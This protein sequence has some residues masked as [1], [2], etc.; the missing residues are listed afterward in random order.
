VSD[1]APETLLWDML[2]GAM[3]TKALGVAA[4]LGVADALAAGPRP[5]EELARV[6]RAEPDVLNR[7]L[8]ALASDGV[9]AEDEPGVFRNNEASELLL[10]ERANGWPQFAHLFAGVFYDAANSLP[11]RA[12]I[13]F[14]PWLAEHPSERAAFD[15]AMAGEKQ[16]AADRLATL[17]WRGDETVVDVGGGNGALLL[18]LLDRRPTLRG[19]ILDLPET[20]R[21]E[22]A[23]GDRITF[24]PGDFFEHVPPGDAYVLSGILHNWDDERAAG[25]LR[26]IRASAS[27]GA[28]VV[29]LESVIPSGNEPN[30][31]TWLDLLMHVLAGGRERTQPEWRA[32]LEA[33]GLEVEQ[34]EDGL[35]QA[36]CP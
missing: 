10:R 5:V 11:A 21:E 19:V 12:E 20:E 13:D 18:A 1:I 32:L 2:R 3:T 29:A 16:R 15:A 22:A 26:T 9:F 28:R 8:R 7:I 24:V 27:N 25:V 31:A 33:A 34:I 4:D 6:T 17:E 30:G 23:F 14:Y 36:R 35:V